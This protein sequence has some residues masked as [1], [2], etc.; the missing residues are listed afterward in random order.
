[1]NAPPP[2]AVGFKYRT[3]FYIAILRCIYLKYVLYTCKYLIALQY[4]EMCM[5][6]VFYLDMTAFLRMAKCSDDTIFRGCVDLLP[7]HCNWTQVVI[8]KNLCLK[9]YK[10]YHFS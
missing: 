2:S 1:M 4:F 6:T 3:L 7:Q 8:L 9:K 10:T 5:Q